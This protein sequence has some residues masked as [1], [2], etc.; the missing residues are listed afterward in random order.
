MRGRSV[1]AGAALAVAL[2][3]P[4]CAGAPKIDI[5]IIPRPRP[6]PEVPPVLLPIPSRD[7]LP[8]FQGKFTLPR[9]SF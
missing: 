9:K 2:G 8:A 5:R 3:S 7:P 4:L 6:E 1:F